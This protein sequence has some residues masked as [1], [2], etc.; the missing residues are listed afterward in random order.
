MTL[1][2]IDEENDELTEI[3]KQK[4]QRRISKVINYS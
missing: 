2:Q 3:Q 4:I 1:S